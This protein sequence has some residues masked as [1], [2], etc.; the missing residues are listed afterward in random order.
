MSHS[1]KKKNRVK[2]P[3]SPLDNDPLY[4]RISGLMMLYKI[5]WTNVFLV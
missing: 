4:V 1:R 5:M 3:W 2:R